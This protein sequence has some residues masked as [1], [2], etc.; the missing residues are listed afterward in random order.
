MLAAHLVPGYFAATKSQGN[1]LPEWNG[2]QRALLWGAALASTVAPDLDV[3]YNALFR[4]FFNHSVL[5]THSIFVYLAFGLVWL[6]LWIMKRAPYVRT[7]AG[8]V[9]CGGLSHLLLDIV[10]HGTPIFYPISMQVF[11]IAPQRVIDGGLWAYLTD[12]IFLLEPLFFG[13]VVVHWVRRQKH[14]SKHSRRVLM[15]ATG[16]CLLVFTMTF[17]LLLPALQRAVLPLMPY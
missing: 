5:W 12:P 7:V 15:A 2:S 10:A 14:I 16:G 6:A 13:F 17:V 3:V 4:G 8:L 11:G 1:W 9:A